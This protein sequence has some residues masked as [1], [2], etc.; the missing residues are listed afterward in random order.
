MRVLKGGNKYNTKLE[1]FLTKPK[2]LG[3]YLELCSFMLDIL[4]LYFIYVEIVLIYRYRA[5][6]SKACVAKTNTLGEQQLNNST[7]QQLNN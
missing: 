4:H 6:T 7:T 2:L 3:F 1:P 5:S